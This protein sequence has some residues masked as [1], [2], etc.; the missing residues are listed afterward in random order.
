MPNSEEIFHK[1][2]HA[3]YI[4]VIDCKGAY[5]QIPVQESDRW[6]TAIVTPIGLLEWTRC[7]FGMKYSGSSFCRTIQLVINSIRELCTSFVDDIAVFST[8]FEEH[9]VHIRRLLEL[10]K[11]AGLTLNWKKLELAKP[12]VNLP[13]CW[14]G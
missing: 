8:S 14:I 7:S 11:R 3:R 13:D 5:W 1:I 4:S 9:L 6:L 10:I 12:E 2:G